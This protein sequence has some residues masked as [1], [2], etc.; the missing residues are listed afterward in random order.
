VRRNR[1]T[2]VPSCHGV[3]KTAIAAT[4]VL[5]YIT[6]GPC[7][8]VTTAPIWS[9]VKDLLWS[10]IAVRHRDSNIPVGGQLDLTRLTYGPDHFAVGFSTDNAEQFA[11]HHSPRLLLV[12]DEASGV[13]EV[14]YNASKGFL[15]AESPHTRVLLIGN[16]TKPAGTFFRACRV[17][18]PYNVIQ[19]S[20]Y[21]SPN[22]T[23]EE[24]PRYVAQALTSQQWID[25][26]AEEFGKDSAEFRIRVLGQ[27]ANVIGRAYFNTAH[28]DQADAL[29][30]DPIHIG[31]LDGEPLRGSGQRLRFV[32]YQ[33]ND[34]T[35]W[36]RHNRDHRYVIFADVAGAGITLEE[37]ETRPVGKKDDASCAQVM[38]LDTGRIVARAKT[39]DDEEEYGRLVAGLGHLYGEAEI[40]VET[41][42][43]Y[44][45]LTVHTI[46][47]RYR[48]RK[49]RLYRRPKVDSV[50]GR[51]SHVVGWDT[52]T[53][54]RPAMLTSARQHL[55]NIPDS[56][57]SRDIIDEMRT[58]VWNDRGTKAEAQPGAHDD[59]VMSF[60]GCCLMR[61]MRT[62]GRIEI[63]DHETKRPLSARAAEPTR[64]IEHKQ[65]TR[66]VGGRDTYR[67]PEHDLNP[68]A[69]APMMRR[70]RKLT[71][72]QR[73]Q[74]SAVDTM[75][76]A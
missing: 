67:R 43:G 38:D 66:I 34:V 44:G 50:S 56:V 5:D 62:R 2:A 49:D 68:S 74:Q 61:E 63:R 39:W 26:M 7:R 24:V 16:P 64:R 4:V 47:N 42:G 23:G 37:Q 28:I 33:Q 29:C 13:D 6:E 12:V 31:T 71:V 45:Q 32:E 75:P 73:A 17:G 22:V 55:K 60:A 70:K 54:T 8:I 25:E 1:L 53:S 36:E 40:A 59:E 20:A 65:Q 58:F 15:T 9:Q 57:R 35:L 69:A 76:G 18:S 3:G 19:M 72:A 30:E 51:K 48:Y 11:G 14:I 21:D 27:F 41:T 52:N 10:E 46:L